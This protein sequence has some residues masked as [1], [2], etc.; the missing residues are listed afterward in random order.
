MVG[1]FIRELI[2]LLE[3]PSQDGISGSNIKMNWSRY[4]HSRLWLVH[5]CCGILSELRICG[6]LSAHLDIVELKGQMT[7]VLNVRR[8]ATRG[9]VR[10]AIGRRICRASQMMGLSLSRNRW[11][12]KDNGYGGAYITICR[13]ARTRDWYSTQLMTSNGTRVAVLPSAERSKRRS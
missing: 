5:V 2:E 9:W 13:C 6:E 1:Y 10:I 8:T 7:C 4:P 12:S 11:M 3:L